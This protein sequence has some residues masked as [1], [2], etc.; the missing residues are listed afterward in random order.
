MHPLFDQPY[1]WRLFKTGDQKAF[2]M[3]Y[4]SIISDL[5]SYLHK[6]CINRT[7]DFE[8]METIPCDVFYNLFQNIHKLNSY[9]HVRKWVFKSAKNKLNSIHRARRRSRTEYVEEHVFDYLVDAGNDTTICQDVVKRDLRSILMKEINNLKGS[10]QKDILIMMFFKGMS[11]Q[12]VSKVMGLSHQTVLNHK[13]KGIWNLQKS[14]LMLNLKL[15]M[16]YV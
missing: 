2:K 16:N 9:E 10:Q 14:K 11:A 8:Y 7:L 4:E 6:E 1:F 3:I 5:Q 13:T 12:Q 15:G